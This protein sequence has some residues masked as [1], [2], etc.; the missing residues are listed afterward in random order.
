MPSAKSHGS[1]Q[2]TFPST[3]VF[4]TVPKKWRMKFSMMDGN[5]SLLADTSSHGE[6]GLVQLQDILLAEYMIELPTKLAVTV[7]E[8]VD[9]NGPDSDRHD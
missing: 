3:T 1:V 9:R 8:P 2:T 6:Q 7:R 4:V 5:V